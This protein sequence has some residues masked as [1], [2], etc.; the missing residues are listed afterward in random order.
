MDRPRP[1]LASDPD[2]RLDIQVAG[3]GVRRIGQQ[4]SLVR[5]FRVQRT[6][7]GIGVDGDRLDA[8]TPAG[9]D[10]PAGDLASIGYEDFLEHMHEKRT[11]L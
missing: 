2:H 9:I 10:D 3:H 4:H 11:G 7:F 8:K 5:E 6:A 1:N